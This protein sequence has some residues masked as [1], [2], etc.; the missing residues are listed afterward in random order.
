VDSFSSDANFISVTP[1]GIQRH[2]V[3][4]VQV[5]RTSWPTG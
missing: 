1:G 4:C 2:N 3:S 5:V